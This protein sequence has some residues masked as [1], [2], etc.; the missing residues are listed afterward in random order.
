MVRVWLCHS[1]IPKL[2]TVL[3]QKLGQIKVFVNLI[4]LTINTYS[5]HQ[6]FVVPFPRTGLLKVGT[7]TA[8]TNSL[9]GQG[10]FTS[11]AY[12]PI[13][14]N[15]LNNQM[16]RTYLVTLLAAMAAINLQAGTASKAP[17]PVQPTVEPDTA[18]GFTLSAGYDTDYV[19]RGV[20]FA[21][22]LV[23]TALDFSVPLT[24]KVSLNLGS[25]YGTSADDSGVFGAPPGSFTELDLYGSVMF[26]LGFMKI[27]PKY[28]YYLY[29]GDGS[30]ALDNINEVGLALSAS[31]G[32][33]DFSGGAYYDDVTDGFYFETGVSST[34][35]IT[36]SISLVPA[37]LVSF[38]DSYY[39]VSSFNHVKIGLSLPIALTKTATLTP[40]IAGN[41]PLGDLDDAGED[42]RVYGGV[43]L[44]V[45]F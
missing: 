33:L 24:E 9:N 14:N 39:G 13:D 44:S 22:N 35:A 40:Y 41:F 23:W 42:S 8:L 18:L 10:W 12:P 6:S 25:W 30:T 16:K 32:P 31:A 2:C 19:F 37:A 17:A 7:A 3:Q 4:E 29:E 34:I 11:P 20:E 43:A 27:G 21:Q 38:G 5:L 15:P 28:T 1:T 45:T 26:D 36:D